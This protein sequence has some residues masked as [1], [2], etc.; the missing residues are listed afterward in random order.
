LS[1]R[2]EKALPRAVHRR[3][4]QEAGEICG[5]SLAPLPFSAI[6]LLSGLT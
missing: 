5:L 1:E 4:Q 3:P 2:I 6:T